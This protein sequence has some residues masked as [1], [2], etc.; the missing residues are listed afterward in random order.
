MPKFARRL[1]LLLAVGLLAAAG[2][3]WIRSGGN[4]DI[5]KAVHLGDFVRP[6]AA[7]GYNVLI[8]TLDTTRADHLGLYG[9]KQGRTPTIDSL[10]QHGVRFDDAV[11]SAPTT[12]PAH[13]TLLTGLYPPRTGVHANGV[14][15]LPDSAVTLAEML[16]A[17][18]Y[19]TAAFV[20]AFVLDER[21]GLNQGFDTYNFTLSRDLPHNELGLNG[22]RQANEVTSDALR[23]LNDHHSG[24]AQ[25][26]FMWVHY[27]DA[28]VP[29]VSPL[30]GTQGLDNLYDAEIAFVDV[31]FRRLL[32]ALDK[33]NL[34]D[35]TL[36]VLAS[37]HGES[38]GEHEFNGHGLLLYEPEMRIAMVLSCPTLFS[39]P[40]RVAD[41]VVGS[42]DVV[43]TVLDLLGLA[44]PGDLDGQSMLTVASDPQRAIYIETCHPEYYIGCSSLY[45][46]RRHYDKF[47]LAP[48][49]EYFDLRKDPGELRNLYG[50]QN[51][52]IAELRTRLDDL[53]KSWSGNSTG[54]ELH[55]LSAED[56]RKLAALGYV[57][58]SGEVDKNCDPKDQIEL[59]HKMSEVNILMEQDRIEEAFPMAQELLEER[60]CWDTAVQ[61]VAAVYMRRNQLE[62]AATALDAFNRKCT[63]PAVHCLLADVYRQQGRLPEAKKELEAA[64][65]LEPSLGI[66]HACLGDI[67]MDEGRFG[68]AVKEY[69][70]ALEVDAIRVGPE[71]QDK[72]RAAQAQAQSRP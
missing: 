33:Q 10:L 66:I 70:Q 2:V 69:E 68:D 65:I 38:F 37:D 17:K 52:A 13:A 7:A 14:H 23:W 45:G 42:V 40:M 16:K 1:V 30:N 48:R 44:I 25:P 61:V 53:M 4:T 58:L 11:T 34:R 56:K 3:L 47:V 26:F 36:I 9:Y 39:A 24:P 50:A 60:G 15:H 21:F 57:Q 62:Q 46:L 67:A 8:V 20:A 54:E 63:D 31:H 49:P 27:Y 19:D 55:P 12:L 18:G 41:R 35:R 72:L 28:H 32:D 51:P 59:E 29:Y 5:T 71:V 22:Q 43:P 64:A 6:S